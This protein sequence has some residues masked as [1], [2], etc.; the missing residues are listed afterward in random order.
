MPIGISARD[1]HSRVQRTT[2]RLDGH[3]LT[4]FKARSTV[5]PFHRRSHLQPP[6]ADV[7]VPCSHTTDHTAHRPRRH[8]RT[9]V[10]RS[11]PRRVTN[12]CS[13]ISKLFWT[14]SHWP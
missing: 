3:Q 2:D 9:L 4:S 1:C 8:C 12:A 13:D 10:G 11:L 7:S 5:L 14:V 6:R